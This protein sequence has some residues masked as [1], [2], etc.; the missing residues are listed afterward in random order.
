MVG[1]NLGRNLGR[2]FHRNP[3]TFAT[4]IFLIHF[5]GGKR[6]APDFTPFFKGVFKIFQAQFRG[7]PSIHAAIKPSISINAEVQKSGLDSCGILTFFKAV[8]VE[9]ETLAQLLADLQWGIMWV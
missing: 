7:T 6:H 5:L 1:R 9:V 3:S 2:P 4:N 8:S